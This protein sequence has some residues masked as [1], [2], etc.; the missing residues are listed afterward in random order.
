MLEKLVG[1]LRRGTIAPLPRHTFTI[2][3]ASRAFRFMAQARHAGKIVVRHEPVREVTIRKEGTY[4]V[5]GGLSGLG[6]VVARWLAERG[7][8]R[9][10]LLG[11]RGVT[12]EST[13]LLNELRAGGVDVIAEALDVTDA[14]GMRALFERLRKSGPPI[15]GVLH[16]AGLLDDAALLQQ[17]ADTFAHVMGPKVTGAYLLDTLTRS[18][19]LDWFVLFSSAASVLGSAGQANHSAANAFLDLLA[20]TRRSRGLPGLS[21]NWGAWSDVG[22]AATRGMSE[23]LA[24]QGLAPISPRQGTQVLERL[25]T[26]DAAQ[27]AVL[28]AD[29]RRF[30]DRSGSR[31]HTQLLADVTGEPPRAH[32]AHTV[33]AAGSDIRAEL[34]RAT[35]A[36]RP[37]IV[38]AFVRERAL[39]ALGL[40]PS[41]AVDPRAPLGEMGLDSLLAVELRNTLGK[42]VGRTLPATLLFDYPTIETL[43]EYFLT[44]VFG[45]ATSAED[46]APPPTTAPVRGVVDAIEELSDEEVDR[47]LAARAAKSAR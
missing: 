34:E 26:G 28:P 23:R 44:D 42:A 30:L 21:V 46:A 15:R 22:A 32:R 38:S 18:D 41:R 14:A 13:P 36:R 33:S 43:T 39:R 37:A 8:G 11:R 17:N 31:L 27:V 20:R 3:E 2:D 5:T 1:E 10:V 12:A 40:D 29:W 47:Q 6:P 45:I 16:S 24:A 35:P 25:M 7:A 19:P 9:L 4:I